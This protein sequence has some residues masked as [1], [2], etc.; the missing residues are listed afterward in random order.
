MTKKNPTAPEQT[1]PDLAAGLA[2]GTVMIEAVDPQTVE[3]D[4][5]I[6]TNPV[7]PE[8]FVDSIRAEGVREPVLARRGEDGTVYVYDGQRRL[9]A[10]REAGTKTMLAVFGIADTTGTTA[11]RVM[12]QLRSFARTDLDLSDR[13]AAY[14]QLALDGISVE[15]IAKSAG[16]AKDNVT[17]ALQIAKSDS[18]RKAIT[19]GTES[20]DRLLLIAEFE[21]DDDA[22]DRV[23]WADEDDLAFVAQRIR[24]ERAITQRRAEVVASYE[25]GDARV[26]TSWVDVT[27]LHMLTDADADAEDRP[28]LTQETH[29]ECPGRTLHVSV[30][31]LAEDDVI[32]TE[33]CS[34]PELHK[35]RWN[36]Y[37]GQSTPSAEDLTEEEA[38]AAAEAKREER[39]RLIANN[40]AWDTAATVRVNWL[41]TL[42]NRKK[43]PTDAAAFVA[44]T[45]TRHSYE[46][47]NNGAQGAEKLL[48][49]E[50]GYS[51]RDAL[52]TL[53]EATPSKA[54]HV[55]LAVALAARENHTN[56]ES[57]RH[58]NQTDRDYLLQIEKWGHHLTD[59]ERIAAGYPEESDTTEEPAQETDA[60]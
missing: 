40:K 5:N 12:D 25:E 33:G 47:S 35:P 15:K 32:V 19:D 31:G 7:V 49:I 30:H 10:A 27:R 54:G 42:M 28:E 6:R 45:L 37:S 39:R 34:Q 8:W 56:R 60:E 55:N 51:S 22:I 21:G 52:A 26:V 4:P 46:V 23:T 48:G 43:L 50:G 58:P 20:F 3:L 16:T 29:M 14:E 17:A 36:T 9:L 11:G 2:A 13:L 53:V 24:D 59:V 1:I 41:M 44:V 18:A 38:E 57:W